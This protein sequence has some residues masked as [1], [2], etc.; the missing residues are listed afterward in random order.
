MIN[1]PSKSKPLI[2]IIAI[3]LLTNLGGLAYYMANKPKPRKNN[4]GAQWKNAMANYLKADI[5]FDTTQLNQY[6][7]LKV[8]HR[9]VLDTLFEQL[10]DEKENRLRFLAERDYSDSAIVQ[11]VNSSAEKQKM[12]D[13]HMLTHLKEVRALCNPEQKN[14]FDTSVYK[15]M[16]RRG[17]EKKKD[18]KE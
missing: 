15:I 10:K 5:G 17:G 13:L 6:E 16:A 1:R 12:L 9:K 11:A 2:V 8:E 3:L 14:R 4:P 18:K 7:S